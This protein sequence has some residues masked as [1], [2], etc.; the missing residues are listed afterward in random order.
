MARMATSKCAGE[1]NGA[2][3]PIFLDAAAFI[4]RPRQSGQLF[5]PFLIVALARSSDWCIIV[6]LI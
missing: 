1:T 3:G 2:A 6:Q 4:S 5:R